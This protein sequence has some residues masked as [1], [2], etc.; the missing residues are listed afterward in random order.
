MRDQ[1]KRNTRFSR[2]GRTTDLQAILLMRTHLLAQE[3]IEDDVNEIQA[4]VHEKSD[5]GK[6]ETGEE[7]EAHFE[8]FSWW[9]FDGRFITTAP[10]A[11]GSNLGFDLRLKLLI[12]GALATGLS[13]GGEGGAGGRCWREEDASA[14]ESFGR[15]ASGGGRKGAA[16]ELGLDDLR[17]GSGVPAVLYETPLVGT[18]GLKAGPE[19]RTVAAAMAVGVGTLDCPLKQMPGVRGRD[20]IKVLPE[21]RGIHPLT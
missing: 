11:C 12:G 21:R 13:L 7:M 16:G 3:R 20:E 15:S 18:M 10:S 14:L 9:A 6:E 19:T 8:F 2:R 4:S 1:L 17:F 5:L